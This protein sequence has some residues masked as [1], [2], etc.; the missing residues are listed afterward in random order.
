[1]ADTCPFC[2]AEDAGVLFYHCFTKR[3]PSDLDGELI[4][5]RSDVCYDTELAALKALIREMGGM[6]WYRSDGMAHEILSRPE[7]RAIMEGE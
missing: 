1:M 5:T 4:F 7:V 6:I 2:G 3:I